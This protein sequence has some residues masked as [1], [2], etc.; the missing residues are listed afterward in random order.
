MEGWRAT[1]VYENGSRTVPS[2][3]H[4]AAPLSMADTTLAAWASAPSEDVAYVLKVK[5]AVACP[6]RSST[7]LIGTPR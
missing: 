6:S 2:R 3:P 4:F 5:A 7:T 1:T